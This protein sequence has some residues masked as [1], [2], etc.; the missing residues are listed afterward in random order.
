[1]RTTTPQIGKAAST[2]ATRVLG[3]G[4][5]T[6]DAAARGGAR[7]TRRRENLPG[8]SPR[9]R[10]RAGLA[11][12]WR[13]LGHRRA[14][15]GR[16]KRGDDGRRSAAKGDI[17]LDRAGV[18]FRGLGGEAVTDFD[19]DLATDGAASGYLRLGD[20][21]DNVDGDASR[22]IPGE[23]GAT[24][25]AAEGIADVGLDG[26]TSGDHPVGIGDRAEHR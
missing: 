2:A 26:D 1:M 13:G 20:D 6:G 9:L 12:L 10:G 19:A 14:R 8:S 4:S 11:G 18:P 15:R 7:G 25:R 23:L 17:Q 16:C 21:I 3:A 24:L 22:A 5:G